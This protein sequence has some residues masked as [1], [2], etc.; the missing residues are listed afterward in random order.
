MSTEETGA[1]V[2]AHV[3]ANFSPNSWTILPIW[4]T[5]PTKCGTDGFFHFSICCSN[6]L[7]WYWGWQRTSWIRK[8]VS[9]L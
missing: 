7:G 6:C 3:F 9:G 2:A 8:T 4:P 1:F 5:I